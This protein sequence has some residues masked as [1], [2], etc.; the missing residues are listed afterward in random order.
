MLQQEDLLILDPAIRD[1]VVIPLVLMVILVGL[2]RNYSQI[3]LKS[4]PVIT[5]SDLQEIRCKRILQQVLRLRMNGRFLNSDAFQRRKAYFIKK[6]T[7]VLREKTPSP[8]NPMS[9]PLA[10]VDMMKGQ[11]T[12]MLPNFAMMGLV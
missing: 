5:E 1:W 9:N 2:G 6:K 11:I 8:G 4:T 10:M 3:L 12:F 7:G